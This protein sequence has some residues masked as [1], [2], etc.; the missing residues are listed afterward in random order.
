[1]ADHVAGLVSHSKPGFSRRLGGV[2][3]PE[4]L[5]FVGH[6]TIQALAELRPDKVIMGI[7][8]LD[9]EA[10]VVVVTALDRR[11]ALQQ[12]RIET[13][14]VLGVMVPALLASTLLAIGLYRRQMQL[15]E[16]RAESE[17][18]QQ[19]N[20]AS[21]FTNAREGIMITSPDGTILDVNEAFSRMSGFD[22]EESL[23][24]NP[25][26]LRS[27]VQEKEF[28]TAMWGNLIGQGHWS[29]EVWNRGKNGEMFAAMLT[30]SAVRDDQGRTRQYVALFTDITLLKANEEKL[31]RTAHYDALTG[32]PNRVLLA[33]RLQQGLVGPA[34]QR[35]DGRGVGH[36]VRGVSSVRD[37][38]V[39]RDKRGD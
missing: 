5:S 8:A 39:S 1:M 18:L 30:I 34:L 14:T 6:I 36:F 26:F 35:A 13:R 22:R 23:G 12:W 27:G 9:P 37:E 25:R 38:R 21:V 20:A 2:F 11:H 33:D 31:K 19:I 24:Q 28:Y 15:A 32:L 17:R 16:Q 29:G 4:E 3:R 10:R 7:R